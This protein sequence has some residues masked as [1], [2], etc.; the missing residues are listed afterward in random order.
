MSSVRQPPTITTRALLTL[1][2]PIVVSR[3]TQV[4]VGVCDALMVAH[5]GG[6]AIAATATGALDLYAVLILPMG[7]VFIVQ[8]FASQLLGKGQ[9][10][11]AHRYGWYGLAVAAATQVLVLAAMPL[12]RGALSHFGYEPDVRELLGDYVLWRLPSAGAAVGLEALAGYYGGLGDTRSP[13]RASL[14]AMVLNVGLN[15]VLI[16]GHLGAPALGVRG[17][18]LAGAIR[19]PSRSC[20]SRSGSSATAAACAR[21]SAAC[22]CASSVRC[23]ASGSRPGSTGSSSSWRSASS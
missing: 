7:T 20:C 12:V 19:A 21:R 15:W 2:W 8:S 5:L 17:A 11:A 22:R 13:M 9:R 4:V 6:A 23:C 18:A 1:A 10:D 3:S 14:L 16:G